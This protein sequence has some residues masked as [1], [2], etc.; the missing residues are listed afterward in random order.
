MEV[1]TRK[2]KCTNVLP[3]VGCSA[4]S[5]MFFVWSRIVDD[6]RTTYPDGAMNLFPFNYE[7]AF[8]CIWL[9]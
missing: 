7:S 1:H 5:S 3:Q 9:Q 2:E 8:H 6:I 4:H